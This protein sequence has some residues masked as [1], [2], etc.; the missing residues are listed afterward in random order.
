M[1]SQVPRHLRKA[2]RVPKPKKVTMITFV[3]GHLREAQRVFRSLLYSKA[4]MPCGFSL[5]SIWSFFF[6]LRSVQVPEAHAYV[7]LIPGHLLKA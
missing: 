4:F 1:K 7:F 3:P 5:V 6:Q 2:D